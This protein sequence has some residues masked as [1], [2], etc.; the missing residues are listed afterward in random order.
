MQLPDSETAQIPT[1]LFGTIL[2]IIG[3]V[4][5]IPREQY[6]FLEKLQ[7]GMHSALTRTMIFTI[8]PSITVRPAVC[9]S[10]FSLFVL[11]YHISSGTHSALCTDTVCLSSYCSCTAASKISCNEHSTYVFYAVPQD[12]MRQAVNGVGGLS[13]EE[14]RSFSSERKKGVCKNFIDGD[15]IEQFVDL[16]RDT[17]QWVVDRMG[18][19]TT[20]EE[21]SKTVEELSRLH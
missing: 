21:L 5:S 20:V 16:K 19:G 2:G 12:C 11:K 8:N 18:G 1:L 13:H 15:L 14:W 4:A 3:V 9:T 6:Q 7:V 10:A 17:M